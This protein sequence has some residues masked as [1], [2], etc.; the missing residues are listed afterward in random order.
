MQCDGKS[1]GCCQSCKASL[2][3]A[4]TNGVSFPDKSTVRALRPGAFVKRTL[5]QLFLSMNRVVYG[6][7]GVPVESE[8]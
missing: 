1:E 4:A 3:L 6:T 5:L 7:F 8:V 2:S